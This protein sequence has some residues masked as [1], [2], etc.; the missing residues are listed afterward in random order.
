[1]DQIITAAPKSVQVAN[2]IRGE[3]LS[4]KLSP[5]DRLQPTRKLAERFSVSTQVIQSSFKILDTE[6]IIES[7]VGCGTFVASNA[8]SISTKTVVLM[9]DGTSDKHA[10]LPVLLPSI[11]QKHG[12]MPY[13]FDV[14][15]AY[16]KT[17]IANLKSLFAEK[18]CAFVADAFSL[19]NFKIINWVEPSTRLV[20][21]NHFEGEKKYECAYVLEDYC[22]GGYRAAEHL[23][24]KGR[25]KIALVSFERKPGWASDLLSK[26]VEE[27]LSEKGL[28]VFKYLNYCLDDQVFI[29]DF[30]RGGIPDGFVC[31]SDFSYGKVKTAASGKGLILGKDF[32]AV[33]Y[34][35][36]PWAEIY[37]IPS[38]DPMPEL[39]S[40]RVVKSLDNDRKVDIRIAPVLREHEHK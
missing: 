6:G 29:N 18:P 32:D 24:K 17:T 36:T 38:M 20:M 2:I 22:T 39:L 31:T 9:L 16:D 23:L 12:Y 30:N 35:N 25:K 21:V 34:G 40:E 33:G 15:Y 37:G 27:A 11:L 26:G 4:R 7:R 8:K 3:I 1:M 10:R 28:S 5:G 19:F 13:L 14:R